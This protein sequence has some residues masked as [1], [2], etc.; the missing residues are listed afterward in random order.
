MR[1]QAERLYALKYG[2]ASLHESGLQNQP[3]HYSMHLL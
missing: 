2:I 1:C 3:E